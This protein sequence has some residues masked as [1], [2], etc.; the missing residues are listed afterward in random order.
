MG[1]SSL[2]SDIHELS[3]EYVITFKLL[4]GVLHSLGFHKHVAQVQRLVCFSGK[5][6]HLRDA[7]CVSC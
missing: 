3:L 6:S 5:F 1:N 7:L 2:C 4:D